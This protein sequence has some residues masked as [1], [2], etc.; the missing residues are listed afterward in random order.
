M[1]FCPNCREQYESHVS[2]C[3]DCDVD[4][5]DRL[6]RAEPA[7]A[8]PSAGG[9]PP[10]SFTL[11]A[12]SEELAGRLA[13]ALDR[14]DCPFVR[15]AEPA[16]V[17]GRTAWPISVPD[18]YAHQIASL[19]GIDPD[20]IEQ[21]DTGSW[22]LLAPGS[23][24]AAG[25]A[26]ESPLMRESNS[27]ILRRGEP[28]IPELLEVVWKGES[29]EQRRAAELLAELGVAGAQALTEIAR[30]AIVEGDRERLQPIAFGLRNVHGYR[31][32]EAF[33]PFLEDGS[34]T[35]RALA[36]I[37]VGRTGKESAVK[38]LVPLLEDP[39]LEVRE[40][41][42]EGLYQITHE[43]YDYEADADPA[44]RAAAIARWKS[45]ASV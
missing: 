41:A 10:H 22:V 28:A 4:L 27:T 12:A 5:V 25:A 35:A 32:D 3:A 6:S 45:R 31:P 17:K 21:G 24:E 8:S 19:L 33:S 23:R 15:G 43:D 14:A 16:E 26:F 7:E 9:P 42:I 1:P 20:A 30:K 40:E 34:A 18:E 11:Y 44:D 37:V 13:N 38:L 36:A 2:R 39:E 29:G